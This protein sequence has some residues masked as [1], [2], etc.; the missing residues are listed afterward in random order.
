MSYRKNSD[1]LETFEFNDLIESLKRVDNNT[2]EIKLTDGTIIYR[3][4]NTNII[5]IR[6]SK[7]SYNSGGYHTITTKDRMNKF[8]PI[9]RH[10]IV[11]NN[12]KWY[13]EN[14]NDTI[15]FYDNIEF[16]KDGEL[17]SE[18]NQKKT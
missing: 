10:T 16:N 11:Q 14:G 2:L 7:V 17:I 3:L 9:D 12:F 15:D 5:T 13:I 6:D 18:K 4:H 1:L 8:T